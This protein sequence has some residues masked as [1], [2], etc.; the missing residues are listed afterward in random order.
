MHPGSPSPKGICSTSI[1]QV[2]GWPGYHESEK[3]VM[4]VSFL[5]EDMHLILIGTKGREWEENTWTI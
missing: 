2:W 5:S 4:I 3:K 1:S